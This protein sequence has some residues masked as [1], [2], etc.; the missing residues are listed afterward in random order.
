MGHRYESVHHFK[1]SE[2]QIR[3]EFLNKLV[4]LIDLTLKTEPTVIKKSCN[5]A[6]LEVK[7]T[8]L[9]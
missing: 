3:T 6:S 5:C 4:S 1:S 2:E 9:D 8:K 7:D